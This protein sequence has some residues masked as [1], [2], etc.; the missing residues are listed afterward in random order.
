M[1]IFCED[2]AEVDRYWDALVADGGEESMCG[3]LK[4]RYGFS[5]QV[6][7]TMLYDLSSDD[8][9]KEKAVADAIFK[10]RKLDIATLQS[11]YDNA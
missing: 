3:W 5:W 7:P 4:D 10:M 1:Q 8:P 11:A 2:Q 9:A 6:V